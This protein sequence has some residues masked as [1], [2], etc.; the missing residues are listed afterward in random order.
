MLSEVWSSYSLL[1][2]NFINTVPILQESQSTL[3]TIYTTSHFAFYKV[4][5]RMKM[6]FK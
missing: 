3:I 4:I 6:T 5:A 2:V 1:I